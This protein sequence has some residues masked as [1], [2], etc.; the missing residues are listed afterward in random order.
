MYSSPSSDGHALMSVSA[1]SP[2]VRTT[3]SSP[4]TTNLKA[5]KSCV[6]CRFI[7]VCLVKV[8]RL[9]TVQLP[10]QPFQMTPARFN[11][12]L[13]RWTAINLASALQSDLSWVEALEAGDV[14]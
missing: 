8:E 14:E 13:L 3:L 12:C 4:L 6:L 2:T 7:T 11:E 1:A 10:Y 5:G 9:L